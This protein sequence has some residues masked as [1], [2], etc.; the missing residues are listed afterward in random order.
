VFPIQRVPIQPVEDLANH[1]LLAAGA[2]AEVQTIVIVSPVS[3]DA[4][5]SQLKGAKGKE[6]HS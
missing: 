5:R 2:N 6:D 3:N 4:H 1:F